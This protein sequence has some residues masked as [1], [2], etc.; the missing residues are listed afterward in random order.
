MELRVPIRIAIVIQLYNFNIFSS[1]ELLT[2]SLQIS[3]YRYQFHP[4]TIQLYCYA[5]AYK[6]AKSRK[7]MTSKSSHPFLSLLLFLPLVT[8]AYCFLSPIY[9]LFS[10]TLTKFQSSLSPACSR[11]SF[12]GTLS[13]Y[14]KTYTTKDFGVDWNRPND[15]GN[16]GKVYFAS[17]GFA[18]MGGQVSFRWMLDAVICFGKR[19][20]Y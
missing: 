16:F 12:R 18:G 20:S 19:E 5:F 13:L 14:A 2:R 8:H 11:S 17:Q 3:L 6:G 7:M 9:P 1:T 15:Q 4:G 10:P